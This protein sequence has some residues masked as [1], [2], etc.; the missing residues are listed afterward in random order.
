[1]QEPI[2]EIKSP[3][4]YDWS[5]FAGKERGFLAEWCREHSY[6]NGEEFSYK[7]VYACIRGEYRG[8]AGPKIT[9]IIRAALAEGLVVPLG[10]L[11][12]AA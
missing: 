8:E 9:E 3:E 12:E 1:M 11:D 10:E 4:H 6:S 7:T 2:K 5:P